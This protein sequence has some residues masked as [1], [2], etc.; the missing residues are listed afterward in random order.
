MD[1]WPADCGYKNC[2]V[3]AVIDPCDL[4]P[5][6]GEG[7]L[8]KTRAV[9]C[10]VCGNLS[11]APRGRDF[12]TCRCGMR[13]ACTSSAAAPPARAQTMLAVLAVASV[14]LAGVEV[15]RRLR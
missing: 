6:N 13:L 5:G 2:H 4:A 9:R 15:I 14:L 1:R 12:L 3:R 11:P 8:S 10:P 7:T